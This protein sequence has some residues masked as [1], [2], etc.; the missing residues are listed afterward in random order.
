MLN[1]EDR[2]PH[3][4]PPRTRGRGH[5]QRTRE[6]QLWVHAGAVRAGSLEAQ[7]GGRTCLWDLSDLRTQ[8]SVVC[9]V[10]VALGLWSLG[11]CGIPAPCLPREPRE[12]LLF[13]TSSR[14]AGKPRAV[15]GPALGGFGVWKRLPASPRCRPGL[16]ELRAQCFQGPVG[17]CPSLLCRLFLRGAWPGPREPL[18]PPES[19]GPEGPAGLLACASSGDRL[20]CAPPGTSV[21]PGQVSWETG[22]ARGAL[23]LSL[24]Q[25]LSLPQAASRLS[26]A[27]PPLSWGLWKPVQGP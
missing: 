18:L 26:P 10:A 27:P 11:V 1:K 19:P 22:P 20:R 17:A 23:S 12:A 9:T 6:S 3:Y 13:Q 7:G 5:E 25:G 15:T 16:P 2:D 8:V 24:E 14:S 4:L 21:W